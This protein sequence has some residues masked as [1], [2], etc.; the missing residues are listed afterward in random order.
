MPKKYLIYIHDSDRFDNLTLRGEKSGLVNQLLNEHFATKLKQKMRA[1][2]KSGS[3]NPAINPLAEFPIFD[4]TKKTIK[5][6]AE[7]KKVVAKDDFCEHGFAPG[8]CKKSK[9]KNSRRQ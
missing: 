2:A 9:C 7:A 8:F 6:P 1:G 5:T 4:P 3:K